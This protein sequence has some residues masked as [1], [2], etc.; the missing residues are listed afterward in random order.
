MP[1]TGC[2]L[3]ATHTYICRFP[4]HT[5]EVNSS[6]NVTVKCVLRRAVTYH[7]HL[8]TSFPSHRRT[9]YICPV[10]AC[11]RETDICIMDNSVRCHLYPLLLLLTSGTN[12]S[13]IGKSGTNVRVAGTN[14]VVAGTNVLLHLTSP[15]INRVSRANSVRLILTV[16]LKQTLFIYLSLFSPI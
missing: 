15:T 8:S 7:T 6:R 2:R 3:S 5:P 14:D 13:K 4:V 10:L 12:D 11:G 9:A 1:S 16:T